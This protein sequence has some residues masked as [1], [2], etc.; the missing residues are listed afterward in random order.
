MNLK[1]S[2]DKFADALI[3]KASLSSTSL[4]EST[5]AFKAVTAYYAAQQKGRKKSGDDDTPDDGEFTFGDET[6][7]GS[8]KVSARRAS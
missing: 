4:Q 7:G 3:K 5:D 2:L 1:S 6:N 8:Q